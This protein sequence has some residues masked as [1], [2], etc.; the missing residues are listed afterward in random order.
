MKVIASLT[1]HNLGRVTSFL[2]V[3]CWP[4]FIQLLRFSIQI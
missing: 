4:F 2:Q 1:C 3:L